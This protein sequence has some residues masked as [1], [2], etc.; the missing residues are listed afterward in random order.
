MTTLRENFR[1]YAD[2]LPTVRRDFVPAD[3]SLTNPSNPLS[4]I[5]GEWFTLNSSGKLVRSCDI[6]A[7]GNSAGTA[8]SWPLWA[9]NGRYDIQ[10]MAEHK[11]PLIWLNDWEFESRIF[12]AGATVGNGLPITTMLQPLKVASVS[13]N[14]VLGT[15]ILSGLVG[16]GG[17]GD[18]DRII[19]YVTRL[20]SANGSWLRFRGGNNY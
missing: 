11:L 16:H 17:S 2:V 8:L 19:G 1:P 14:G 13:L 10:A 5:D 15:R 12:D 20:P 6:T 3:M 7:A 9:E 4:F 18:N